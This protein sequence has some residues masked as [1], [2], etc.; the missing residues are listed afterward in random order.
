VPGQKVQLGSGEDGL[1]EL[2][3]LSPGQTKTA[4]IYMV[5]TDYTRPVGF[6][7]QYFTAQAWDGNPTAGSATLLADE[8]ESFEWVGEAI[9]DNSSAEMASVNVG[10]FY[11]GTPTAGPVVGGTMVMTVT[12]EVKNKPDRILYTPASSLDW[13]AD[14]FELT[15]AVVTYSIPPQLPADSIFEKPIV[16]EKTRKDF[17]VVYTFD[18]EATTAV[19]TPVTPSQYTANG[20]QAPP[21]RKFEN[22][23]LLP[24]VP[25]IPAAIEGTD[26]AITKTGATTAVAGTGTVYS[27]TITV[28][29]TGTYAAQDVVVTDVW[30]VAFPRLPIVAP[31]GTTVTNE[32]PGGFSWNIGTLPAGSTTQL[33]VSFTVP[34]GTPLGP[35]TNT[36]TVSSS[37]PDPGPRSAQVTTT[38]VSAAVTADLAVEKRDF[39]QQY[40]PG[41]TLTWLITVTNRGPGAVSGARV[42]DVFPPQ[43]SGAS[44]T[45]VFNGGSGRASGSGAIDELI[46]L[47]AGGTAIYTVTATTFSTATGDLT[48]TV[49]VAAPTGVVDPNLTNNSWTDVDLVAPVADL[50]ITKV[51][52]SPTY[53]PGRATTYTIT[54]T[55]N[56]PSFVAGA[57]VTDTFSTAFTAVAWTATFTG[58][59][60]SGASE[61]RG[62]I[63]QTINL[64]A[65]GTATYVVTAVVDSAATAS[66]VNSATVTAPLNTTDPNLANNTATDTNTA[67]TQVYLGI[68]KTDGT[69]TYTPGLPLTYVVT[70][71]NT[72][73][74]VLTGGRLLDVFPAAIVGPTWTAA[75]TG[76]GSGGA[77]SGS[78]N[79][80]ATFS[81]AVGGSARF[82][83]Q[84][85]VAASA[86]GSL[87]NTAEVRVPAGTTNT[88]PVTT[89]TDTDT[90]AP[91]ADLRVTK[92]D[93]T[94]V[95]TPGGT[96]T[97]TLVVSNFGPS[98]VQ[99]ARL[100]D[101]FDATRIDVANVT[102]AATLQ[103]GS[104]RGGTGNI[105]E[106]FPIARGNADRVVTFV[107]TAPILAGATGLLSNTATVAVPAGT[108]DPNL[109]NNVATDVDALAPYADLQIVKRDLVQTYTPGRSL[110]YTITVAN[111]GTLSVTGARV[112]DTFDPA[113]VNVAGVTWTAVFVD[114]SGTSSGSGDLDELVTLSGVGTA[115]YTVVVPMLST[116]TGAFANT[117]TVAPPTGVDDFNPTNNTW[118]DI[119]QPDP[120][121]DLVIVKTDASPTYVPGRTTVYTVTVTNAGPSAVTGARV[122]DTF[123][124]AFTGVSWTAVFAGGSGTSSGSGDIDEIISL[125]SLGT[126][127]YT[128]TASVS[129]WATVAIAN[130]ATVTVPEGTTDPDLT[131]NASTDTN[132]AAP[133]VFLQIA[134]NDDTGTYTPGETL[135]YVITVTN[136]GPSA[137]VGG[138]LLD[139]LPE[140]IV[141]ATWSAT[142]SGTGST[143]PGNGSGDVDATFTLAVGGTA[144]FR[145]RAP[146]AST[147]R[148]SLSNTATISVPTGTTNTNP[149]TFA[150]DV[151]LVA[152]VAD[153]RVLKTDATP[154]Y[155]PGTTLTYT[156]TVSNFGPSAVEFGRVT[157]TFDPA[158][159]D[160]AA[161]TWTMRFPDGSTRT[162]SGDIDQVFDLDRGNA[163]RV[164]TIEVLA[165]VRATASGPLANTASVTAPVLSVDY[166]LTNNQSTH[167]DLEAPRNGLVTGTDDG[168][169]S[170]PLVRVLDPVTG[171]VQAEWAAY[172]AGFRGGVRVATADLDGD[173]YDEVITAPGRGRVGE[174]RV[175][176]QA[177]QRLPDYTLLPYGGG[178]RG[179]VEVTV[180][181]VDGDGDVDIVTGMSSGAGRVSVFRV[182]PAAT[183]PVAD[184]PWKSFVPFPGRYTG[185]VTVA[186]ADLGT[187]TGAIPVAVPDG[188]AEI[189][190]GSNAGMVAT[191]KIYDVSGTPRVVGQFQPIA[192]GF[193]GGVTLSIGRWDADAIPDILVGAG[194]GGRSVVEVYAGAT[195]ARLARLTAFSTFRKPN[196]KVYATSLDADGDGV[197]DTVYAVQGQ[198]GI[199]GTRGVTS[200]ARATGTTA[201]LNA[202]V[203]LLP[204]LRITS[205]MK[206]RP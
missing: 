67:A 145:V 92:T 170:A 63:A 141:G 7:Y 196:A 93:G 111:A 6:E 129:P 75:Y 46:S 3:A 32:T 40:A 205:L 58:V 117:A 133:E 35:Y 151:D 55:N 138:R 191:V 31:S 152:P 36:A 62:S 1:Y 155:V 180:G 122:V 131:N 118:T 130:T 124:G 190:V 136:A 25:D 188:R 27:Y 11:D 43:V 50:A 142:Y 175:W 135:E 73:P 24:G 179:G 182:D 48:N 95:Y 162:G 204:P 126:A 94:T 15:S 107:V 76:A 156:I 137:L 199:A 198:Q 194:V 4:Y 89:A 158:F 8:A 166:N 59:G 84:A 157:D 5:A 144:T 42:Q 85:P 140:V 60:S 19:P 65:G 176:T 112:Q 171:A 16:P 201:P 52:G 200:W 90:P 181:D 109:S 127:T 98:D 44:W 72:G 192:R 34:A 47:G 22:S 33:T 30:P 106:T 173:G 49:T 165:P 101:T 172:E 183:D 146:V 2:G 148:G 174:V 29:S 104:T 189:V 161:V 168:C 57:S 177:G 66:I 81:L 79:I 77:T 91:L 26:L 132:T 134:K 102:W 159:F 105:D 97:Y 206:K 121:A 113:F 115:T 70:V 87:V 120:V 61:G 14:A 125:G 83:I 39:V 185:G 18:I 123:S 78:G 96:T 88:N 114:D 193:T 186:A 69:G 71:T 45:A 38:V 197:I 119:D 53:V 74:S 108:I 13:P 64:A 100:T 154:T 150:T 37:T 167:V 178:W 68:T 86:T 54:V 80:D 149:V 116:A 82:T 20:V 139:D 51:D 143:G 28:T 23:R 202:S 184:A 153:L 203:G 12:G 147:A 21:N 17:N 164:I 110:T 41:Q 187:F 160:V 9:V 10:Y 99:A 103:D 56:G 169:P 128:V 163:E 195:F